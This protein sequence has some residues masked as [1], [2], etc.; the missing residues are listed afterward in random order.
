MLSIEVLVFSFIRSMIK[1]CNQIVIIKCVQSEANKRGEDGKPMKKKKSVRFEI[2][3][4]NDSEDLTNGRIEE[5]VIEGEY[6]WFAFLL[7]SCLSIQ[8]PSFGLRREVH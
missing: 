5:G 1:F 6:C 8:A 3:E 4:G 7:S 2:D